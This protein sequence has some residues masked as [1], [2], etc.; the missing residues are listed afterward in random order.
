MAPGGEV[1]LLLCF[2]AVLDGAI[3]GD[4]CS[5]I[6]DTTVMSSIASACDHLDHVRT[7]VPYALTTMLA[8]AGLGYV[9]VAQ[10]LDPTLALMGGLAGCALAL[11]L[12]G[13]AHEP[14]SP[15]RPQEEE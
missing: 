3:F 9:G 11:A 1:V 10:G 4:H 2:A 14:A 12:L 7:Q 5:P 15:G 8:A 6:S 13:R